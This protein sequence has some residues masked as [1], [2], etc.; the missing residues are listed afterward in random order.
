MFYQVCC[1]SRVNIDINHIWA[2]VIYI[3]HKIADQENQSREKFEVCEAHSCWDFFSFNLESNKR[4]N[5]KNIT[6]SLSK[7]RFSAKTV[8]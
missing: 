6:L 3:K 4:R 7:L 5:K 1:K 8:T 2:H